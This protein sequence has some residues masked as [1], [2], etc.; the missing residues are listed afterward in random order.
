MIGCKK[1]QPTNQTI[2]CMT[3][4]HLQ[5][6]TIE[7]ITVVELTQFLD[8]L[9]ASYE[10]ALLVDNLRKGENLDETEK[11][12]LYSAAS[13]GYVVTNF[14]RSRKRDRLRESQLNGNSQLKIVSININ[15]PG[16]FNFLGLPDP[17]QSV[18]NLI[19]EINEQRRWKQEFKRTTLES[20]HRMRLE[21]KKDDRDEIEQIQR[22][23]LNDLEILSRKIQLLKDTGNSPEQI[24]Q[25][26]NS[27]LLTP[28][29]RLVDRNPKFKLKE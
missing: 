8:D 14:I 5:F 19:H 4:Q 16:D 1:S 10:G 6:K 11:R 21:K 29:K 23:E 26:V 25:Y 2:N 17:I 3:P 20:K 15:S 28:I 9:F 18:T 12:Y 13:G 24:Q 27:F 7:N 22:I